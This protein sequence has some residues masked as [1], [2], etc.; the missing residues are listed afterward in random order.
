MCHETPLL[1]QR[2]LITQIYTTWKH[3]HLLTVHST[4]PA[5]VEETAAS[6]FS[7][8][9]FFFFVFGRGLEVVGAT[10]AGFARNNPLRICCAFLCSLTA[11]GLELT[12]RA[13]RSTH[14]LFWGKV[15][16]GQQ[17][18]HFTSCI[19]YTSHIH[20]YTHTP[21][22][23][24]QQRTPE[25]RHPRPRAGTDGGNVGES[26]GRGALPGRLSRAE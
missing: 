3:Q 20:P 6:F 23:L 10:A 17:V 5:L 1:S 16:S 13:S 19:I 25:L 7:F 12:V 21:I 15:R 24:P 2:T 4:S 22:H 11:V 8:S 14:L 26:G 18:A 9:F